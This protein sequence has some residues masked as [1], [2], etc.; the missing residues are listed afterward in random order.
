MRSI[1]TLQD[2]VTYQVSMTPWSI[3]LY[4]GGIK[5]ITV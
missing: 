3:L 4:I 5:P 1:A 2:F